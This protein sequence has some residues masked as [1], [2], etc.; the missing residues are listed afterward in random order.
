M[1]VVI[2]GASGNIG[3]LVTRKAL[4]RGHNVRAFVRGKEKLDIQHVN[5]EMFEG[6]VY[7]PETVEKAIKDQEAVISA[8]GGKIF[9]GPLIC[10]DGM[11]VI[12]PAMEKHGVKRLVALSAFGAAEQR[13][14]SPYTRFLRFSIP[15]PMQDKDEMEAIIRESKLDWTI[16]RP[17]GFADFWPKKSYRSAEIL[18][19]PAP[20]IT[21][22]AVAEALVD[23]LENET[24]LKKPIAIE[25]AP[26]KSAT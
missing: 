17:G 8:L 12:L 19:S 6:D 2:F 18:G 9:S 11:K 21:K 4:D 16:V 24:N 10:R 3:S 26:E 13:S 20:V 25:A 23:Q 15:L 5:L 1:N 7:Q 14:F 22:Q